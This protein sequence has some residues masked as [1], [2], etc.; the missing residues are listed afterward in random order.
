M[1][2]SILVAACMSLLLLSSCATNNLGQDKQADEEFKNG[3][4]VRDFVVAI[5]QVL[6]P[7]I[8]TVQFKHFQRIAA[9]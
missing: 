8:T 1:K 9:A 6:N 3:L 4:V 7:I 5:S 2:K